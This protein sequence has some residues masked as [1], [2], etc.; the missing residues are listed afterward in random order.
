[1]VVEVGYRDAR[2]VRG[3]V[4][5]RV[6]VHRVI[7]SSLL[8]EGHHDAVL[9]RAAQPKGKLPASSLAEDGARGVQRHT[10]T[11]AVS[12]LCRGR[13]QDPRRRAYT[14]GGTLMARLAA[15]R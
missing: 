1:M 8:R 3:F 4:I 5:G 6:S 7:A 10:V 14:H 13:G 15:L 12:L 9:T 11:Q 2:V